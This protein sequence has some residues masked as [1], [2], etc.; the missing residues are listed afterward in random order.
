MW[1]TGNFCQVDA[2]T[3]LCSQV[4][5]QSKDT[6]PSYKA[7]VSFSV[8]LDHR[9]AAKRTVIFQ[10]SL[11]Q[12]LRR[13]AYISRTGRFVLAPVDLGVSS[14]GCLS[15]T[16]DIL[17]EQQREFFSNFQSILFQTNARR[18]LM[19]IVWWSSLA[20]HFTSCSL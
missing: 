7:P 13:T 5:R 19:I 15:L 10:Y 14:T 3:V 20:F 8:E 2:W 6:H 12:K 4:A 11:L 16:S 18:C 9:G 1:I 17:L